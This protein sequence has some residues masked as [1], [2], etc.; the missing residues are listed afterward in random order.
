[1]TPRAG[2]PALSVAGVLVA[3]SRDFVRGDLQPAG[4]AASSSRGD[5][6][7]DG[8]LLRL[9]V[10]RSPLAPATV[11][12]TVGGLAVALGADAGA[13]ADLRLAL[14][15]VCSAL[16]A[17]ASG[18][19]G[20]LE[21]TAELGPDRSGPSALRVLLRDPG[22]VRHAGVMPLPLL[23]ALTE[24]VELH[25]DGADGGVEVRLTFALRRS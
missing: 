12:H 13:L 23:V 6:P 20:A 19:D 5:A 2:S 24:S 8:P 22:A 1:M 9:A 18:Y 3:G 25:E 21:V 14:S 7:L 10:P 16:V 4:A 11:R 17:R 15:E